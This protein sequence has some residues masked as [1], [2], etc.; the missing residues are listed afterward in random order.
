ME[1]AFS[2]AKSCMSYASKGERFVA[3]LEGT[4]GTTLCFGIVGV[5]FNVVYLERKECNEL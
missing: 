2:A 3:K 1:L 5:V 4:I